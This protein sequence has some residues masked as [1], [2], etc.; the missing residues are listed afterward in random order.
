M[1]KCVQTMSFNFYMTLGLNLSPILLIKK[2]N[3]ILSNANNFVYINCNQIV[4]PQKR[5]DNVI[6]HK[7]KQ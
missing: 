5:K 7:T 6:S 3:K 2:G 1:Q 4:I